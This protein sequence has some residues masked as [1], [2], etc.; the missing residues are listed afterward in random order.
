MR[1]NIWCDVCPT[2]LTLL[3]SPDSAVGGLGR[4]RGVSVRGVLFSFFGQISQVYFRTYRYIVSALD[5]MHS[6]AVLSLFVFFFVKSKLELV[7]VTRETSRHR[8]R[9]HPSRWALAQTE[10][11]V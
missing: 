8:H 6:S 9:R 10:I 4:A 11:V 7:G 2:C 3:V 5:G 1:P